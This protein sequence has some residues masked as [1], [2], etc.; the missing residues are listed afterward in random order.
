MSFPWMSIPS[1]W[2]EFPR[3]ELNG[4][5]YTEEYVHITNSNKAR[6]VYERESECKKYGP[7]LTPQSVV[8]WEKNFHNPVPLVMAHVLVNSKAAWPIGWIDWNDLSDAAIHHLTTTLYAVDKNQDV[9]RAVEQRCDGY[10]RLKSIGKHEP[11][12][13]L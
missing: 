2:C 10:V 8:I 6:H 3:F 7:Y 11:E 12:G 9:S 1:A 13:P 4:L 5:P